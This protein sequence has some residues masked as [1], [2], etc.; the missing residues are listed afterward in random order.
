[1]KYTKNNI[2]HEFEVIND[3]IRWTSN[4]RVPPDDC[5]ID[6]VKTGLVTKEQVYKSV[7]VREEEL[8]EFLKEY[9]KTHQIISSEERYEMRA[10]F[11]PGK[12]VV[13]VITGKTW[14][15]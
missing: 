8:N 7:Q 12:T 1:M 3:I 6:I 9:R 5:L 15:T 14:K 13:N 10:A 4:N 2:N 11:G